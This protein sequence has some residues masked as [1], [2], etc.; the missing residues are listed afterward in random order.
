MSDRLELDVDPDDDPVQVEKVRRFLPPRL[1]AT[2]PDDPSPVVRRAWQLAT[3]ALLE[4]L[5]GRTRAAPDRCSFRGCP[6]LADEH[7]H[8]VERAV[9]GSRL[10]EMF[11][12]RPLC[13]PHHQLRT[14][15][16]NA[17]I[18]LLVRERLVGIKVETR[19]RPRR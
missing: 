15:L 12:T 14:T 1:A 8:V 7:D 2:S 18:E 13:R 16:M 6:N 10:A 5:P 4:T 19:D 17:H 9:V 3:H 11:G